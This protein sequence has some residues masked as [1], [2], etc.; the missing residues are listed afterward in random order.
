MVFTVFL[1][2]LEKYEGK[3][4]KSCRKFYAVSLRL[5]VP[6]LL[7]LGPGALHALF[8]A[9]LTISGF[10]SVLLFVLKIYGDLLVCTIWINGIF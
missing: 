4:L 8:S 2:L 10:S 9:R 6:I 7:V 3:L 1:F 5:Y